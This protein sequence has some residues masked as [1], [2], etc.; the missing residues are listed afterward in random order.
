M[1]LLSALIGMPN[2]GRIILLF[3]CLIF[4]MLTRSVSLYALG[5]IVISRFIEFVFFKWNNLQTH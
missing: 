2:M 1:F 3:Y 5:G 4:F